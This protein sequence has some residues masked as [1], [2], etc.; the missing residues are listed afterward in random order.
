[1]F[2]KEPGEW[3]GRSMYR[4]CFREWLLKDRLLNVDVINHENAGG[5]LIPSAPPGATAAQIQALERA[6]AGLRVGNGGRRPA[7]HRPTFIRATGSD[8]IGSINRHDEAMAREF[9][10]MFMALG[11]SSSGG[12]RAL[13]SSF[14]DWFAISQE[15]IAIWF[16]DVFN[17]HVIEDFVDQNWATDYVPRLVPAARGREPARQPDRDGRRVGGH[18]GRGHRRE[19]AAGRSGPC[20]R[21]PR[22]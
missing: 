13:A 11:T 14:I 17:E 16:R 8:V 3:I 4:S 22:R 7:R 18:P 9:L 20:R 1:V 19:R 6:G 2:E 15:A 21:P 5:K 12:N 10:M